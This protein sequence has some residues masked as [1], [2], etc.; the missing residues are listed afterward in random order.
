MS[1]LPIHFSTFHSIIE[2]KGE[3]LELAIAFPASVRDFLKGTDKILTTEPHT[4]LAGSYA[5]HVAT[6][7]IKDV[8]I[9]LFV[10]IAYHSEMAESVLETLFEALVDLPKALGYTGRVIKKERQRRSIKVELTEPGFDLDIVPAVAMNGTDKS[11]EI[12]DRDWS[13]WVSS[14][15]LGYGDALSKLNT[16]H[17][18]KVVPLIKML[19]HWRDI[20]IE[21]DEEGRRHPKSYWLECM[22]YHKFNDGT[23][24][25]KDLSFAEL[26]RDLLKDI[27]S[28]YA[29]VLVKKD[30]L[31][32]ISDPMLGHD[33]VY[34]WKRAEFE[35]F[36][37]RIDQSLSWA[38][39]ALAQDDISAS[40]KLWQKV[41]GKEY[42]PDTV[43]L[44]LAERKRFESFQGKLFVSSTGA[45]TIEKTY[46][47]AVQ[48]PPTRFYGK[49][50]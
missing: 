17:H 35:T 9:I 22:V 21:P 30:N 24:K 34:N 45:V 23:L 37:T 16:E 43:E 5:R 49:D 2:P 44:E 11:L 8:D 48:P 1:T 27:C 14:H 28:E 32:K 6:K 39:S 10:V 25:T 26:F 3:R 40:A 36:M 12:P 20:Q 38:N 50:E 41:F 47:R 13:K 7:E 19:K 42:F 31:P 4:R 33:V 29:P 18:E 15:P 46:N